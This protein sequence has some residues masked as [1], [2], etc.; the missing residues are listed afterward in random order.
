MRR[1][2]PMLAT[3]SFDIKDHRRCFFSVAFPLLHSSNFCCDNSKFSFEGKTTNR[4]NMQT[5]QPQAI[6]TY[7]PSGGFTTPCSNDL[8]HRNSLCAKCNNLKFPHHIRVPI[9]ALVY[10]G[11]NH[12]RIQKITVDSVKR[13]IKI[14]KVKGLVEFYVGIFCGSDYINLA[15]KSHRKLLSD[16]DRSL[17][18]SLLFRENSSL[19]YKGSKKMHEN[20]SIHNCQNGTIILHFDSQHHRWAAGIRPQMVWDDPKPPPVLSALKR[21]KVYDTRLARLVSH[22]RYHSSKA[23]RI[24]TM[25]P[26]LK[27]TE[28]DDQDCDAA[29]ILID[30]KRP[31]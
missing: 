19:T 10:L 28:N 16:V 3:M 8:V 4:S 11:Q 22:M 27:M 23:K 1:L 12:P 2:V 14:V 30:L 9:R 5:Q 15:Q 26:K 13:A 24:S 25:V 6:A 18:E 20:V 7:C 29:N 21:R 31:I 17:Y